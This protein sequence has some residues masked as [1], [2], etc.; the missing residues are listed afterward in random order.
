M[1]KVL[2]VD[3]DPDVVE[4]CRLF[5]ESKGHAVICAFSRAE[6]MKAIQETKPE[7][8]IL[9]VMMEQPDDG[10]AMA[11]E[12]RRTGYKAPILMLTSISKVTG[13]EYGKDKDLVPVDAFLEKPVSAATLAAKV[14]ELLKSSA[15]AG[16]NPQ[17][18]SKTKKEG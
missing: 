13:L 16:R 1:A 11:Q 12:L 3:D 2:V 6:G 10:L 4:A 7:L 15:A 18:P 14:A 8:L 9:D 17:S 5:L